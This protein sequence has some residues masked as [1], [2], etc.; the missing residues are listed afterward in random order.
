M[1]HDQRAPGPRPSSISRA[2]M[3]AATAAAT[4]FAPAIVRSQ[5]LQKIR[6][7]GVVTDD[8]TPVFYAIRN[9]MYA[10][11]GLDVEVVPTPTGAAATE[12]VITGAYELGKGSLIALLTAHLK[13][14]P[15]VIA[16][17]GGLWDPKSPFSLMLVPSD[18]TVKT[19]ADLNGKTLAS[20]AL[21][22]LNAL[23]MSAWIERT[24]GD[25]KSIKWIEIPNSAAGAALA[26]HR[27]EATSLNEPQLSAAINAGAVRVLAPSYS[28]IAERFV[29]TAY[30][31]QP[32]WATK[33][34]AALR[35]WVHTTYQAATYTNRHHA[36]TVAMMA[37]VTK[38]PVPTISTMSRVSAATVTDP[39]LIQPVIDAAA[40]YGSIA[41]GFA[42]K[43]TYIGLG[44]GAPA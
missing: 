3:L 28:A 7:A 33:N 13:G 6:L 31:A 27:V 41:H 25:P 2:R 32:D 44:G 20:A 39:N 10:K 26:A 17:N 43:D 15:I 38:I 5:T 4:V 11:A 19:G 36:E 29:L 42:A 12:A 24:G 40:K 37:D 14:L 23:G 9:G 16:G 18:S 8:L 1:L 34:A 22:D 30:F 35:A 21:N